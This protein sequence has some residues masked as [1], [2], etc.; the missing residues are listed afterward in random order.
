MKLL[1]ADLCSSYPMARAGGHRTCHSLL[2]QLSR[3][4]DF[5]T[6]GLI[7]RRGMGS[8]LPDYDPRLIDFESLGIREVRL[9]A[10]RWIFDVGYPLHAVDRVE[11]SFSAM[12]EEFAP[13]VVWSNCFV[14]LPLLLQACQAEVGGIWYLH[15][16]RPR[17][18]DLKRALD[19]GIRLVAVSHFIADRAARDSGG[20]CD[21]VFPLINE[22]DYVTAPTSEQYVTFINP[23]PVKGY[24]VFL[25]IPPLLPEVQ[26][27][28][29]EAWPLGEERARV[30][31]QLSA[32]GNVQ[33]QH[34][35]PDVRQVYEKTRLLLVPS[36]VEEGGPRVIREAQLNGIPVLGSPLG[37]IPEM[38]GHG[39]HIV[40]DHLK[41]E[42]W[43]EAIRV[44][45]AESDY[46]ADLSRKARANAWREDL[47]TETIVQRF[48]AICRS[49]AKSQMRAVEA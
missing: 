32:L 35:L 33:F 14:S 4:S 5:K 47:R 9:A 31:Q 42:S 18:D 44:L 16:R 17:T 15:D 12:L 11:E 37:G 45:L 49:A 23:R 30:S 43:A 3:I 28:V 34:Q 36:V 39:G 46:Y 41:P 38:V 26:F 2:L 7:P 29:V 21:V 6:V 20:T 8:R 25:G 19:A 13:D 1:Q 40:E 22:N 48:G 10:D 27:L 24:E